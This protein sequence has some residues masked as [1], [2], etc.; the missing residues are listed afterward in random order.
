MFKLNLLG[1]L[2]TVQTIFVTLDLSFF[3]IQHL[4]I[5]VWPMLVICYRSWPVRLPLT[6]D[7][8]KACAIMHAGASL[9]MAVAITHEHNWGWEIVLI[10]LLVKCYWKVVMLS[11]YC[12]LWHHHVVQFYI[13]KYVNIYSYFIFVCFLC[14]CLSFVWINISFSILCMSLHSFAVLWRYWNNISCSDFSYFQLYWQDTI[15]KC[16]MG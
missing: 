2:Y 3:L 4:E 7:N 10:Y 13:S 12:I 14:C 5:S 6:W 16:I 15:H 1:Y 11:G 8:M 9:Q